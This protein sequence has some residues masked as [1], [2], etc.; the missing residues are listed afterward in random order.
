MKAGCLI[1]LRK[2]IIMNTLQTSIEELFPRFVTAKKAQGVSE[3]TLHTYESHFHCISKHFDLSTPIGE[4][5]ED[6][7][8]QMIVSMRDSGLAHN[9]ISSYMRVFRTFIGWCRNH[10]YTHLQ[11]RNIKDRETIK[12]TYTDDELLRLLK[13]PDSNCSF[14][15]FRNWVI[16]NFLLNSGCRAATIRCI[17]N[18]DVDLPHR[19]IVLR[20]TKNGKIQMIPL[21]SHMVSILR[22]YTPIRGGGTSDFLFCDEFGEQLSENAL[23]QAIFKYNKSRGVSRTSIHAFRHTF[24]RKYLVDCG[25]DAFSLQK[26]MG[27]STLAMTRHYCNIFNDDIL[28]GYEERSPLAQMQRNKR[29]TIKK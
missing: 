4:L 7:V 16:I 19:Q 29:Q 27:H 24:A 8:N 18:Q 23:R 11:I 17:Q 20:H 21:C 1:M 25:G 15:E 3:K 28:R 26:L 10:G 2:P 5:S 13:K 6:H 12:E 14:S 9:S 22:E